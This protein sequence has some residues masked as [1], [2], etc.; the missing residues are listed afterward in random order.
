MAC[1]IISAVFCI[2]ANSQQEKGASS[3]GSFVII[4]KDGLSKMGGGQGWETRK[5][6]YK[7]TFN[8]LLH[9]FVKSDISKNIY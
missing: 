3:V 6:A 9:D 2:P 1:R 5:F 7:L 8:P 4:S